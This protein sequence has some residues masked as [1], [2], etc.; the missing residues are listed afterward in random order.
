MSMMSTPII[1]SWHE[2]TTYIALPALTLLHKH[3]QWTCYD[4][5][6]NFAIFILIQSLIVVG[7]FGLDVMLFDRDCSIWNIAGGFIVIASASL[8]SYLHR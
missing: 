7:T 3:C 4:Y 2:L 8:V 6:I 5:G 1:L